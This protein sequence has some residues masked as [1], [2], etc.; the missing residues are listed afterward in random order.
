METQLRS[1]L[2]NA[3]E[4]VLAI[5]QSGNVQLFNA[6]CERLFGYGANEVIGHPMTVLITP[7]G[8]GEGVPPRDP[9]AMISTGGLREAVG[10]RK[11]G[12]AFPLEFSLSEGMA[13]SGDVSIAIIHDL[14][15][16]KQIE[17]ELRESAEQLRAVVDT[18]VDGVILIDMRGHIMMFNPACEAL[19]GY[20]RSELIGKN[21]KVLMPEPFH[22]EHDN[23]LQNYH[24]SGQRK[25]IGIGREVVGRRKD[26]TTFPM[27]LSVGEARHR[28]EPLFVGIIRDIT[29]R[30]RM[31]EQ[32]EAFISQLAQSNE[33]LGYFA[34]IASHDLKQSLRMVTAFC[35]LLSA[36]YGQAL[37]EQGRE[38]LSLATS[39][40][41]QMTELLNDMLEYGRLSTDET[42][43][44]WFDSGETLNHVL[45]T[46][47]EV[48]KSNGAV[49][50]RDPMPT[51]YANPVRFT[52]L[53]ENL[54]TNAIKYVARDVSPRVR[55]SAQITQ[56][57]WRFVVRD[58]GI[59]IPEQY[60]ERIF[61]PFKRLHT[62]SEYSGT[63]LG[64]AICKRIVD[65]FGGEIRVATNEDG[66]STFMFTIRQQGSRGLDDR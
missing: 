2:D 5:D 6:A 55:V 39:A 32:R 42:R 22:A 37:D 35:G 43:F 13:S 46:L 44:S 40:A 65:G 21:V 56:D 11:D 17:D 4:S 19:F 1:A 28:G 64:L 50:D 3:L 49:I 45:E 58:N 7:A 10:R 63:G 12:S 34:H 54:I 18:A 8:P 24:S 15:R 47:A 66:G 61:E 53:L 16:R 57:G 14:T 29:D 25:I 59:G 9:A 62:T 20:S 36:R 60:R 27:D 33:E 31:D 23:Y 38:F 41:E 30:K 52:R 51:I 26:G 48:T